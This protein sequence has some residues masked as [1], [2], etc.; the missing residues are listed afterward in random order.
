MFQCCAE[1]AAVDLQWR[2]VFLVLS[3]SPFHST[4]VDNSLAIPHI[5]VPSIAWVDWEALRKAGFEGCVLD[6]D[7]TL[8]HPYSTRIA[9]Q[10]VPSLERCQSAFAGRLVLFSNSAGLHQFD[11][12][13]EHL[14][15]LCAHVSLL[16]VCGICHRL[17]WSAALCS[18]PEATAKHRHVHKS[19]SVQACGVE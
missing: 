10:L 16:L 7:N 17:A 5:N 1:L 11:P 8:T 14:V 13:G 18:P 6:K 15:R 3:S 12:E 19:Q 4:Q 2:P 9:P